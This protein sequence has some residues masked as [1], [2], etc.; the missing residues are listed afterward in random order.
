MDLM[1]GTI[2]LGFHVSVGVFF[3]AEKM[4]W[5]SKSSHADRKGR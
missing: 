4:F 1:E 2:G 3:P 5:V